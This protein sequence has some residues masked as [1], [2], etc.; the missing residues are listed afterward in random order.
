MATKP[1][2]PDG[3]RTTLFE[4]GLEFQDFVAE[5]LLKEL[6]FPLTSYCSKKY[7]WKH[8][9]N[10]QGVEIKLDRRCAGNNATGNI[11]FE[12]AEKSS[13]SVGRWTDSGIMREDNTWLYI[14]GNYSRVF[15]FGKEIL[16]L[17]YLKSFKDKVREVRPT[18]KAFLMPVADAERIALKVFD[19]A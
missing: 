1:S 19:I 17:V 15:V 5:L 13:A 18:L 11:S 2:Y 9:E 7:Q 8:G 10:R 14:Q 16:R 3:D 12:V 6:G 4:E